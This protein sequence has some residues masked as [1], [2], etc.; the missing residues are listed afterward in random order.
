MRDTF[1][2]GVMSGL[3]TSQSSS[4][5]FLTKPHCSNQNVAWHFLAEKSRDIITDAGFLLISLEDITSILSKNNLKCEVVAQTVPFTE[6][7]V[8]IWHLP[9]MAEC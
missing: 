9:H 2:M 7:H 6:I 8:N 5:S 3:L 1:S 4:Q